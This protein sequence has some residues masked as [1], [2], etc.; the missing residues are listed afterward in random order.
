MKIDWKSPGAIVGSVAAVVV[1]ALLA[2]VPAWSWPWTWAIFQWLIWGFLTGVVVI[3]AA[4]VTAVVL[5][6]RRR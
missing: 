2:F 1:L 4:A 5:A 6:V 3:A